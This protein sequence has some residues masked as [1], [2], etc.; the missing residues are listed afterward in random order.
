MVH[1]FPRFIG[2]FE[3][4]P[5]ALDIAAAFLRERLPVLTAT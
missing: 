2:T 1:V 4:A 5:A 3:A